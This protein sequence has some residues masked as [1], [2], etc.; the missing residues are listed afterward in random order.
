[1]KK[2]ITCFAIGGCLSV[3]AELTLKL[4][5]RICSDYGLAITLMLAVMATI[6]TILAALKKYQYFEEK[7]G[8]G[9]MLPFS[10]FAS[11]IVTLTGMSLEKNDLGK[12]IKDGLSSAAII[13]G[14][15][16][17]VALIVAFVTRT[18]GKI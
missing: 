17:P 18:V 10:G 1:M 7:G 6:G 15:G 13:F 9:A 3:I 14:I 12:A 2:Y 5:L 8:Y 16:F 4:L 11:A